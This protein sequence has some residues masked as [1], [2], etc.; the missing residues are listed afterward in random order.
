LAV[1][2]VE[3]KS[4]SV[5]AGFEAVLDRRQ[6]G[7]W[8]IAP[9]VSL[10]YERIL[11]DPQARSKGILYSYTVNQNSAYDSQDLFKAGLSITAQH[12]A[13]TIEAKGSAVAGEDAKSTGVRGGFVPPVQFLDGMLLQVARPQPTL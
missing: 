2:G 10:A 4:P 1:D 9:S 11:G 13:F 12:D 8:T 6:A 7:G 3:T 5:L